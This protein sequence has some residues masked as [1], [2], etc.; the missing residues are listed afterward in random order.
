MKLLSLEG[1]LT[2]KATGTTPQS[3]LYDFS[4][5]E[6]CGYDKVF[7]YEVVYAT[8]HYNGR[9]DDWAQ[10]GIPMSV[11]AECEENCKS[12]YGWHF[13]VDQENERKNAI[14]SFEDK[15]EAFWFVLKYIK[16]D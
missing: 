14:M 9:D 4:V 12:R 13:T 8:G 5:R 3:S 1:H 7:R 16:K 10:V 15:G 6:G 2:R 11:I